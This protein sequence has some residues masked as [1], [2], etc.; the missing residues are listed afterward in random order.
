MT[1]FLENNGRVK[2]VKYVNRYSKDEKEIGMAVRDI[3][4]VIFNEKYN[5]KKVKRRGGGR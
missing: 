5:L 1:F 3:L 4:S 2:S